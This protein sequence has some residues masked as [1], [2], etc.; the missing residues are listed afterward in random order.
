MRTL[1]PRHFFNGDWNSGGRC[2]NTKLLSGRRIVSQNRAHDPA[3]ESAVQGTR[4]ES[5][6]ITGIS[7]LRDDAH[8]SKYTLKSNNGS[9]DCLHWCLPGVPDTW[10]E[11]LF[12]QL[13][14]PQPKKLSAQI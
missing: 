8:L 2:D 4:V 5:L 6:D 14:L 13:L 9:Q 11:V 3:A 12:A 1:S 10:N 7:E